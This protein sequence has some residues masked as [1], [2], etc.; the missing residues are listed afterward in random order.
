MGS[1]SRVIC[2][3]VINVISGEATGGI[4][5][6]NNNRFRSSVARCLPR[7][8]SVQYINSPSLFTAVPSTLKQ[9]HR[10]VTSARGLPP[11][12]LDGTAVAP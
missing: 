10:T 11:I 5:I 3:H 7:Q 6:M 8:Y 4:T 1:S 9:R 2:H 12:W